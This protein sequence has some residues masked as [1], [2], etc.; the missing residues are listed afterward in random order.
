MADELPRL[1]QQLLRDHGNMARLLNVLEKEVAHYGRTGYADFDVL[2]RIMDYVLHFPE[3]RHHPREDLVFHRLRERSP[4]AAHQ[5][6]QILAEH[7]EL[8]ALTRK[9]ASALHNLEHG[10]TM[11]RDWLEGLAATYIARSREHMH[12]EEVLYFPLAV[13]MLDDMDWQHLDNEALGGGAD[14][15][16]GDKVDADYQTLH[17]RIL[18]LAR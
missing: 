13:L 10:A 15:L 14:P 5:A 16:F 9:L 4:T 17:D 3:L 11:Q 6:D 18:R 8:A 12:K 7:R 2:S 1:V